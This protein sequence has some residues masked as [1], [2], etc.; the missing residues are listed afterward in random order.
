MTPKEQSPCQSVVSIIAPVYNEINCLELFHER[1]MKVTENWQYE[2]EIIY[3]DDGSTDGSSEFLCSLPN[4]NPRVR[5]ARFARNFGQQSA[6]AAGFDLAQGDIVLNID[7]D[8]QVMPEDI[9][10]LIEKMQEG[11]DIVAGYRP[12]RKETLL[13]RKLPSN[14]AN[15]FFKK[16]LNLPYRDVGCGIQAFRKTMIEG[17]DPFSPMYPHRT[18]YAAWRGG[19]FAEIPIEFHPR[20]LGTSKYDFFKLLHVFLDLVLTFMLRQHELLYF[21]FS[22]AVTGGL[23]IIG[24]IAAIIMSLTST[25]GAVPVLAISLFMLFSGQILILFGFMN[26]RIN[27]INHQ[28]NKSPQYVIA[29]ICGEPISLKGSQRQS[30]ELVS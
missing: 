4:K 25:T 10:R 2:Y 15:L 21:F 6:V 29:S 13:L 27:R 26:E 19:R 1:L 11:Y 8:L 17:I 5:V 30:G 16:F 24:L 18:I 22:G 3:V 20:T 23:G 14:F 7:V 12:E 9:P 28:I